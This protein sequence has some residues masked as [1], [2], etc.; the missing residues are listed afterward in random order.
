MVANATLAAVP[1]LLL[2]VTRLLYRRVTGTL[3]TGIDRVGLEYVRR[4]GPQAGAVLS[5]G[6]FSA[7]LSPGDSARVF[8]VLLAPKAPARRLATAMVAKAVAWRWLAPP[9]GALLLNT[10]HTGLENAQYAASL[11]W[12]G[13][14][15]VTMV[16]DLIPLTHPQFCRPREPRLHRTRMRC[17]ARVSS[18]VVANSRD[19]LAAFEAFCRAQGLVPPPGAVAHLGNGLR[20]REEGADPLGRPYF[21]MLSTLEPRKNHALLL[22]VWARL[23]ASLGERTPRLVLI[24]QRGWGCEA[25]R[26]RLD[27]D[28]TLRPFVIE[29]PRCTDEELANWLAHARALLFPSFAEGYGLPLAEAL[30]AGLP[31]IASPLPAFREIAGDIPEYCD[32]HDEAA[33]LAR[34]EDYAMPASPARARQVERLRAFRAPDWERHF[35][36]VRRVLEGLEGRRPGVDAQADA[37][38]EDAPHALR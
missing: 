30:A 15:V 29:R 33:W 8:G 26:T 11:R 25:V 22:R 6:P 18:A 14:R 32:P 2:D 35:E 16:H 37:L 5:L 31:A 1:P 9:R 23:A 10:S 28:E 13:A 4:F 7:I 3:P 27:T 21:V 24:G 34:I 38:G 12:R 19:T 17:A 20:A 36:V